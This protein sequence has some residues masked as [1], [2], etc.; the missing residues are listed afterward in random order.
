MKIRAVI[1]D[2]DNTLVRF[3][4]AR[5]A[6]LEAR[7]A[8]LA[9]GLPPGAAA[10]HWQAWPGPWPRSEAGEPSFW[11]LFWSEF[12]AR[13]Q[14]PSEVI[15]QLMEIGA[16]YQACF[17]AFPDAAPSLRRL[18][19][20]GL[21]LAVLTNFELPSVGLTL[22]S[23]GLDPGWFAA[24]LSSA[25][26]GLRKPDPQAYLAAA[27]AL[28]L[29]PCACAFVDDMPENVLGAI[30]VGMR[31]FLLDRGGLHQTTSLERIAALDCLPHTNWRSAV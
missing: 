11:Q 5:M 2:R 18:Y 17:V 16:L 15:A 28:E 14:L 9:P 4:R 8:R 1:F 20:R 13:H 31:G 30:A 3:D 23:A 26:L 7:V 10:A 29:P 22:H 6:A 19:D 21:H 12:A 27:D 24:L 25:K